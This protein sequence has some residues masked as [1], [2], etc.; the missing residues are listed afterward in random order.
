MEGRGRDDRHRPGQ[1]Q[2]I[3]GD[4]QTGKTTVA[5]DTILNQKSNWES[6][7][8]TKQ[9]KVC[10][11]PS[12]RRVPRSRQCAAPSRSTAPWS[13]PPSSPP[14][15]RQRGLQI[16]PAPFTGQPWAST[17]CTRVSTYSSCSTISPLQAEAYRAVSLLLRRPPGRE[18]YPATSSTCTRGCSSVAPSSATR[19]AVAR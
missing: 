1:R 12:V 14:S 8:P 7:D 5:L 18:A 9:V 6:G 13:T 15:V 11:S 19:W 3:I 4:R 10:M 16:V 17:G 2:L